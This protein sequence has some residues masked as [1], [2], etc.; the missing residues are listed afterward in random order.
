MYFF[1][2]LKLILDNC[3]GAKVFLN[4][5]DE[6]IASGDLRLTFGGKRALK[7][8]LKSLKKKFEYTDSS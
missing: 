4:L 7:P 2:W 6:D 8:V 3:V 5:T 1:L